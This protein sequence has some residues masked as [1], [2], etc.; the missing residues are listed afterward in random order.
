MLS[1]GVSFTKQ[2]KEERFTDSDINQ[3]KFWFKGNL[4]Y[5]KFIKKYLPLC[6]DEPQVNPE[7]WTVSLEYSDDIN[8]GHTD[9]NLSLIHI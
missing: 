7:R 5:S 1:K 6:D 9:Y 2:L 8:K 3:I 4:A